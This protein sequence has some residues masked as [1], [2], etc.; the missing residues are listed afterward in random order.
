MKAINESRVLFPSL[1]ANESFARAAV[2]AFA[3]QCDPTLTELNDLRTAVSEAVTNCIVHAYRD[4]I[5]DILLYM[6]LFE[7]G[8][9]VIKVRDH[10]CGIADVEKAR[11]PLM[12]TGGEERA[13][14]GFSVRESFTDKMRVISHVGRGTTVILEKYIHGKNG[15]AQ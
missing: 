13:G 4:C 7:N 2:S 1:S 9:M 15:N 10:G 11:E 6:R 12:T 8:R 5:G 14:L 3:L